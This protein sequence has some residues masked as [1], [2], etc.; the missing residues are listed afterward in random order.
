MSG[1]R[2]SASTPAERTIAGHLDIVEQ[3]AWV[4]EARDICR[5][6]GLAQLLAEWCPDCWDG[7]LH[8]EHCPGKGATVNA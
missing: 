6:S 1:G 7:E 4:A 8:G 3:R 5:E 2:V